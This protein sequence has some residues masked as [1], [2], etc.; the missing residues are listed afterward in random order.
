MR[1]SSSFTIIGILFCTLLFAQHEYP[2]E[3]TRIGKLIIKPLVENGKINYGNAITDVEDA[4]HCNADG[5]SLRKDSL[6]NI[7]IVRFNESKGLHLDLLYVYY[8]ADKS[9]RYQITKIE[10]K[11]VQGYRLDENG[12]LVNWVEKEHLSDSDKKWMQK[13]VDDYLK[14]FK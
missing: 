11:K 13:Q 6:N 7:Y 8:N 12:K 14:K 1:A 2:C 4:R 5:V 3:N 10:N 9:C